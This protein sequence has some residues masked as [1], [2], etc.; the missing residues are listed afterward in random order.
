[1]YSKHAK[2]KQILCVHARREIVEEIAETYRLRNHFILYGITDD[3]YYSY[4]A[5]LIVVIDGPPNELQKFNGYKK[6][7]PDWELENLDKISVAAAL[8]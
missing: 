7:E 2:W 5:G 4:G 3:Y 1:M 6:L 8:F